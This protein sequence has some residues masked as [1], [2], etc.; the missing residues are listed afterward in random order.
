L[1]YPLNKHFFDYY[2]TQDGDNIGTPFFVQSGGDY[3]YRGDATGNNYLCLP[4]KN[5]PPSMNFTYGNWSITARF[6]CSAPG[7]WKSVVSNRNDVGPGGATGFTIRITPAGKARC[8]YY[9]SVADVATVSNSDI[10]DGSM[11][12]VS[13]IRGGNI[14]YMIIDGV[15]QK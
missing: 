6:N 1:F 15:N 7:G 5:T 4:A 13:C 12:T 9:G 8:D 2:G 3:A 14:N 11:V 10:C